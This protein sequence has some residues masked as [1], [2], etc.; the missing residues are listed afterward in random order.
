[1][2]DIVAFAHNT[3]LCRQVQLLQFFA[4]NIPLGYEC[5]KCDVCQAKIKKEEDEELER[6]RIEQEEKPSK[7]KK[8]K[9]E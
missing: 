3:S 9:K 5:G 7:K 6:Q 8:K 1:M 4:E 2:D